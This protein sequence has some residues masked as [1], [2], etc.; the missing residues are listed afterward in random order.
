MSKMNQKFIEEYESI[1][2]DFCDDEYHYKLWLSKIKSLK[3][4]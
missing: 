2:D 1:V 3:K 4:K